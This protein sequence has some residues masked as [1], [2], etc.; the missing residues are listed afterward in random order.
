MAVIFFRV[1]AAS[2]SVLIVTV[3]FTGAPQILRFLGAVEASL[4]ATFKLLTCENA[5]GVNPT[6][7]RKGMIMRFLR[8]CDFLMRLVF[9]CLC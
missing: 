4:K 1:A 6:P 3:K 8:L 2:P 7:S 5:A 9:N